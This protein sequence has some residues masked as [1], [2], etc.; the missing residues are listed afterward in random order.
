MDMVSKLRKLVLLVAF[1]LPLIIPATAAAQ[2]HKA[3]D[4]IEYKA[5]SFP[6]T[7]EVGTFVRFTPG[8]QQAIILEKPNEWS[9]AGFQKAYKL[10]DI[11]PM[12]APVP[13][14]A[15]P[16]PPGLPA[17][18]KA[19]DK[20]EYKASNYPE[21]WQIGTFVR[22]LENGKQVVIRE[23]PDEFNPDGFQRAYNKNDVRPIAKPQQEK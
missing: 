11:R 16:N 15:D 22:K 7:W 18:M 20:I 5:V 10:A 13:G 21:Q 9:P 3:G 4:K 19:G 14:A 23:T 1:T 8:G 12:A 2:Q 17:E 6:E